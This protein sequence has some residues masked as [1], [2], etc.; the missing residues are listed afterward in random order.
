M[1]LRLAVRSFFWNSFISDLHR[2]FTEGRCGRD[3]PYDQH[4][5]PWGCLKTDSQ[6]FPNKLS[7]DYIRFS[8]LNNSWN[9]LGFFQRKLVKLHPPVQMKPQNCRCL[10]RFCRQPAFFRRLSL[11]CSVLQNIWA[12]M[13]CVQTDSTKFGYLHHVLCG[14]HDMWLTGF[15]T[16]TSP[17]VLS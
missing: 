14:I 3:L 2:T 8:C 1:K 16:M 11:R 4:S 15:V 12:E 10:Q 17:S 6:S 7:Y 13:G 5:C 9:C